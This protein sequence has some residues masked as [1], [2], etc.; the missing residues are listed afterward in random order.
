METTTFV[1]L[2][3]FSL[4]RITQ[5]E[6]ESA[7]KAMKTCLA[8]W[9]ENYKPNHIMVMTKRETPDGPKYE[10]F[11]DSIQEWLDAD[12]PTGYTKEGWGQT[13]KEVEK[14]CKEEQE[15]PKVTIDSIIS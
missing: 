15:E 8:D 9:G 14:F 1:F 7:T 5:I 11:A 10:I 13:L 2:H 12:P 4:L 3:R 6:E